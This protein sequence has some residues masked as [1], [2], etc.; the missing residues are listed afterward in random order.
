MDDEKRSEAEVI[1]V[2]LGVALDDMN[3][4]IT[5][6]ETA[7]RGLRLG[8][9]ASV[10]LAEDE[11]LVFGKHQKEWRLLL[12]VGRETEVII[13]LTN[14]SMDQRMRAIPFF[15]GLTLAVLSAAEKMLSEVEVGIKTARDFAAALRGSE[16]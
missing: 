15:T 9:R 5:E 12:S 16:K 2:Q 13:P 1:G 7:I 10:Q 6:A 3:S 11:W 4:A 8:V 14:A